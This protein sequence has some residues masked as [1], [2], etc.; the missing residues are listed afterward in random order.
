MSNFS[1]Q[2]NLNFGLENRIEIVNKLLRTIVDTLQH[3]PKLLVSAKQTVETVPYKPQ[4]L[5]NENARNK[6]TPKTLLHNDHLTI[7]LQII[8]STNLGFDS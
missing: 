5:C 1:A 8:T 7:N 2:S 6:F 3:L 4:N